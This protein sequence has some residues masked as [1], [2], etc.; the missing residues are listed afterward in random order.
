[1]SQSNGEGNIS[2]YFISES[3]YSKKLCKI[4]ENRN[5]QNSQINKHT[6]WETPIGLTA[7]A[8]IEIDG[9]GAS[10]PQENTD[11]KN[12]LII[13]TI[14]DQKREL[15]LISPPEKGSSSVTLIGNEECHDGIILSKQDIFRPLITKGDSHDCNPFQQFACKIGESESSYFSST[16]K[17]TNITAEKSNEQKITAVQSNRGISNNDVNTTA[18]QRKRKQ[19][20]VS[21]T[22]QPKTDRKRKTRKRT[23]SGLPF[24]QMT[25]DDQV[26]CKVKWQSFADE[27][28][29]LEIRRFQVFIAARLHCQSHEG[30][31]RAAMLSL[32]KY[33]SLSTPSSAAVNI[34]STDIAAEKSNLSV[35]SKDCSGEE[36]SQTIERRRDNNLSNIRCKNHC[37]LQKSLLTLCAETLSKADP[38]IISQIISSVLFANVKSKQIIKAAKEINVRFRGIVPETQHGLQQLTGIGPKLGEI[39]H[40]VNSNRAHT[41]DIVIKN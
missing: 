30:T 3:S 39:L 28:A 8:A 27:S 26:K 18:L 24:L 10:S 38:S 33:F 29:P 25:P 5:C 17:T 7:D 4:A 41:S 35:A 21:S 9:G 37:N 11:K 22:K 20:N 15:T 34:I 2:R 36:E 16:L 13:S 23:D 14:T 1:M 32:R 31:V 19:K 6:D 40:H 12:S